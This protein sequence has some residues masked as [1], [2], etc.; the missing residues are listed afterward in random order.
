[1]QRHIFRNLFLNFIK[2]ETLEEFNKV[3]TKTSLLNL[4][5][6][7]IKKET[8][9]EFHEVHTKTSLLESILK[10]LLKKSF[11]QRCYL[12]NFVKFS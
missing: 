9:E 2:K 10:A 3:K 12:M 4:F 6:K 7:I 5:L 11:Y 8:L 1:M